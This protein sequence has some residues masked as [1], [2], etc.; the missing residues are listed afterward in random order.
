MF[1]FLLSLTRVGYGGTVSGLLRVRVTQ[2]GAKASPPI[3]I[4]QCM[5]SR[6]GRDTG[7]MQP[8]Y[9]EIVEVVV[10]ACNGYCAYMV[11]HVL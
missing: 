2:N 9:G 5:R 1:F 7:K 6:C 3:G 10:Y 11:P 8:R 4:E